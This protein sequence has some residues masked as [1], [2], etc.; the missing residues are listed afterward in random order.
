MQ[1]ASLKKHIKPRGR[2]LWIRRFHTFL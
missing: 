2:N 1:N